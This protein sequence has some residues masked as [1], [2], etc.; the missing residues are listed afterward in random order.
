MS[1]LKQRVANGEVV[2]PFSLKGA[3]QIHQKQ[4]IAVEKSRLHILLLFGLNM[5]QGYET[6]FPIPLAL[7]TSGNME[8]VE[9]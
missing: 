4:Q 6:T 8:L 2:S 7:S 9:R 3:K 1:P 5:I